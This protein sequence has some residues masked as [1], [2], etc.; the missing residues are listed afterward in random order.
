MEIV[1][2]ERSVARNVVLGFTSTDLQTWTPLESPIAYGMT[3]L[4]LAISENGDLL[5]T[6]IQEVLPPSFWEEKFGAPVRGL[7]FDG[8]E[9][10]AIHWKV[11]TPD[12]KAHIDPQIFEDSV[13]FLNRQVTEWSNQPVFGEQHRSDDPVNHASEVHIESVLLDGGEVVRHWSGM[14]VADPS[15]V[16]FKDQLHVFISG[17]GRVSHLTGSPLAEVKKFAGVTVPFAFVASESLNLIVQGNINGSRQPM[18]ATSS[19]GRQWSDFRP[20]IAE[21]D[22]GTCTSPVIGP[23]GDQWLLMCAQERFKVPL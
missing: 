1:Q 17:R 7:R 4:G 19:D 23:L 6:G 16:R 8:V 14:H 5:L 10:H 12:A 20:L 13:W 22:V 2:E 9:W 18:M 15:P 11:D 21:L 3:S